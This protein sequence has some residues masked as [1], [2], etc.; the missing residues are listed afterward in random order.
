MDDL[1]KITSFIN[2]IKDMFLSG[3]PNNN[4]PQNIKNI[5]PIPSSS[6]S[7][8]PEILLSNY[9]PKMDAGIEDS[10]EIMEKITV[11]RMRSPNIDDAEAIQKNLKDLENAQI[12]NSFTEIRLRE[13]TN[14]MDN[15]E[16]RKVLKE[17]LEA[18]ENM[19]ERLQH[20]LQK[21]RRD[22]KAIQ[23]ELADNPSKRLTKRSFWDFVDSDNA[24]DKTTTKFMDKNSLE[25]DDQTKESD[26][27]MNEISKERNNL[28]KDIEEDMYK[29]K[30][31]LLTTK[32]NS[33]TKQS[34][35]GRSVTWSE[36]TTTIPG[37][38]NFDDDSDDIFFEAD[39][40]G[41]VDNVFKKLMSFLSSCHKKIISYMQ[42][43]SS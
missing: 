4:Q 40:T 1:V 9:I 43:I 35:N 18:Y 23:T 7:V 25:L 26:A 21:A 11:R 34:S 42:L 29:M 28:V 14:N 41:L 10:N 22:I 17:Q 20:Q 2:N 5:D 19:E 15:F 13:E 32:S 31:I 30:P 39:E 16:K 37:S 38:S 24:E 27:F 3:K 8:E 33:I 12:K 36:S 6:Q